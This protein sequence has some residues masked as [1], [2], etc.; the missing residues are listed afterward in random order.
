MYTVFHYVNGR[1]ICVA[2]RDNLEAAIALRDK[3]M[4]DKQQG[5]RDY[6]GISQ[7]SYQNL[8][9]FYED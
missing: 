6:Y 7:N 5:E 2:E 9:S 4:G 8:V 3:L 1:V